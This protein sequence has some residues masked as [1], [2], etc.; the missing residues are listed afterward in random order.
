MSSPITLRMLSVIL[1]VEIYQVLICCL[2]AL[3]GLTH[4]RS[5][6]S[7]QEN[8]NSDLSASHA[9]LRKLNAELTSQIEELKSRNEELQSK[10]EELSSNHAS[11]VEENARIISQLDGVKDELVSV[12][13]V[14]AGLKSELETAALKVQTIAADAMLSARAELMGEFKRG[15][16]SSWDPNEEIQTW[17]KRAAVLAGGEVSEDEEEDVST[18][19]LGS[20]K[21]KD[22]QTE[23][24]PVEPITRAKDMAIETREK[25]ASQEDITVD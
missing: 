10:N 18:P 11:L 25:A 23:P 21:E 22:S 13:A 14:S 2:Q 24:E 1:F 16:Y 5:Q 7:A 9:F 6:I 15:E 3:T 8:R 17:D 19:A 4:V 12:K 20:L